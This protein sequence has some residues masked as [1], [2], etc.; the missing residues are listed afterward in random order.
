M[1][2]IR[3][4]DDSIREGATGRPEDFAANIGISRTKL[5]RLLNVMKSLN[6]PIIFDSEKKS[7]LYTEPV[8]FNFGFYKNKP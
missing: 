8:T 5:H 6:A 1:E 4:I 3:R 2:I 7:Y